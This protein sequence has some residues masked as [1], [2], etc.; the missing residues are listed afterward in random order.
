MILVDTN[1]WISHLRATDS[2]L[3]RYLRDN[4]AV[5]SEVVQGELLLGA[6]LPKDMLGL[7]RL[8]PCIPSPSAR[9]TADFILRR[10]RTFQSSGV[11]WA[12]CQLIVSAIQAGALLYS[13][14]AAVRRV[15]SALGLRPA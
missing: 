14:D 1:A 15:W 6:G 8:L 4:R 12:D 9:E 5:T 13:S 2:R 10:R 3:V 7:L 11:G